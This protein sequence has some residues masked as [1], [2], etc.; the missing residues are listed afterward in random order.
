MSKLILGLQLTINFDI[1][2]CEFNHLYNILRHEHVLHAKITP[3]FMVI[4]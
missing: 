3:V 2:F 1:L 4:N